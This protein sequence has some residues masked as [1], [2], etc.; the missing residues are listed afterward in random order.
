MSD[1][2]IAVTGMS[3]NTPLA[4]D[5][6][7]HLAALLEGRSAVGR[8]RAFD[9]NRIYSKIAGDLSSY[10]I[11]AKT[12][13]LTRTLPAAVADRIA[14]LIARSPWSVKLSVLLAL[15][16][17]LDAGLPIPEGG[18][19]Q[20][21]VI[22]GGHNINS[23]YHHDN[24]AIF[25]DEP[26]YIDGSYAVHLY[27]TTHVGCISEALQIK[28]S[29]FT[30]GGACASGGFALRAGLD[31]LRHHDVGAVLVVGAVYDSA[32]IDMHAMA[33]INA[34]STESFNDNPTRAS[35]PFDTRREGFVPSHGGAALLLER[36]DL[37]ERRR[38]R[39]YAEVLGVETASDASHLPHPSEEGE[40]RA[41]RRVLKACQL[42]PQDVD[43]VNG[44]FTSTPL[45]DIAE[46]RA[47][48]RVFGE[49]ARRL[50]VNATKSM[51]GHTMAASFLVEAVGAILQ[52]RVGR[53]HP[54]INIDELDPAVDLD[55]CSGEVVNWPVRRLMKNSF[56]F[57]GLNA[58]AVFARYESPKDH[59]Q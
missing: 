26:D 38:A 51:L 54:T 40:A 14:R 7:G 23:R 27:D 21:S 57:G 59:E 28:G 20:I 44:H 15:D 13:L 12:K 2:R 29:G 10:D 58:S 34:L 8:W 55:V 17:Y 25:A 18:T 19:D 39:I 31:E 52:M 16:A 53:L 49:H 3:I 47:I 36:L 48:K 42:E 22:V 37:A 50:K 35:R 33:L 46:V 11:D 32:P 45:G 30:V 56:G 1:C 4:D 24:G 5:L 9:D 41:M 43:Y 6:N